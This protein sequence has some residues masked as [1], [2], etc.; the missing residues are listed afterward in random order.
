[1]RAECL[2]IEQLPRRFLSVYCQL[3]VKPAIPA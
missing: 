1:M 2:N 3:L